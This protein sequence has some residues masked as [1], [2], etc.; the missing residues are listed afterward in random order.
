[1]YLF[2]NGIKIK[3]IKIN[4]KSDLDTRYIVVVGHKKLFGKWIVGLMVKPTKLL[5]TDEGN[6]IR[7][8]FIK[9]NQNL[10]SY[11]LRRYH[12]SKQYVFLPFHRLQGIRRK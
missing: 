2:Y 10:I 3:K 8:T 6:Y 11:H 12:Y 1:M 5:K 7:V 4:D 9:L